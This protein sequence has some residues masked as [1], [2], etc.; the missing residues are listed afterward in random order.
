MYYAREP[1]AYVHFS[2]VP[3]QHSDAPAP[4]LVQGIQPLFPPSLVD[5]NSTGQLPIVPEG[6]DPSQDQNDVLGN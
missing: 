6:V 1:H 4:D 2:L 3:L 5:A